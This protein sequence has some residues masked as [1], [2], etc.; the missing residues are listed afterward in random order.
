MHTLWEVYIPSCKGGF[1]TLTVA[2]NEFEL[3]KLIR[4][5]MERYEKTITSKKVRIFH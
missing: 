4:I 2:C 1:K 3:D 5:L